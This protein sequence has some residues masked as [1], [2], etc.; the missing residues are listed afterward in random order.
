MLLLKRSCWTIREAAA[1]TYLSVA[2][3]KQQRDA[4][5]LA[6]G[7]HRGRDLV[8]RLPRRAGLRSEWRDDVLEAEQRDQDE[9]G[10]DR[11]AGPAGR[12][13]H[14]VVAVHAAV[15]PLEAAGQQT[16]TL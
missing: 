9:R 14:L 12:R 16:I 8:H 7:N 2:E 13:G 4:Q 3:A 1:R 10:P 5:T 15:V 11:L 6:R